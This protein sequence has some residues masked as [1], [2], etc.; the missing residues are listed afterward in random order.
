MPQQTNDPKPKSKIPQYIGPI[1]ILLLAIAG[2]V[3]GVLWSLS[4]NQPDCCSVPEA[5]AEEQAAPLKTGSHTGV[6]PL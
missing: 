6:P 1:I 3:Y 2:A 4:Y 5:S